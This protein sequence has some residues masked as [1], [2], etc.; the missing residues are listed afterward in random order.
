MTNE[1]LPASMAR[2]LGDDYALRDEDGESFGVLRRRG[3]QA[4]G[5]GPLISRVGLERGDFMMLT[6]DLSAADAIVVYGTEEPWLDAE[7]GQTR[8]LAHSLPAA[9]GPEPLIHGE[10]VG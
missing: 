9:P 7:N 6:F 10:S 2:L 3:N 4:W 1:V 8:P 5:L